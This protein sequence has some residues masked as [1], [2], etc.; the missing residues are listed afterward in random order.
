[1]KKVASLTVDM[2]ENYARRIAAGKKVK[3]MY[4][5]MNDL[6]TYEVDKLAMED[7]I[8]LD[9]MAKAVLCSYSDHQVDAPEWLTATAKRLKVDIR[10]RNRDVM[11]K[12]LSEARARQAQLKTTEEKRAEA[13]SEV[14]KL[15]ALLNA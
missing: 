15:T 3:P 14:E 12:R 13:A 8:H 6:K 10:Q 7:L 2:Q 5:M 11:E 1:M 4:G 9:A